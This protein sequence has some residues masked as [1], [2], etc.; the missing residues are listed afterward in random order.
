M[1]RGPTPGLFG[2][3]SLS[4]D[5]RTDKATR[6][7][8][9]LAH[10]SVKDRMTSQDIQVIPRSRWKS[11]PVQP[12]A[13]NYRLVTFYGFKILLG[14]LPVFMVGA[15][16]SASSTWFP[17]WLFYASAAFLMLNLAI[18]GCAAFLAIPKYRAER[19]LGYTTWPSGDELGQ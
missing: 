16:A 15:L 4:E 6:A 13:G 14:T 11:M 2:E 18:S 1:R 7:D 8:S 19:A 12:A 3:K 9:R 5:Q 17:Q 10:M